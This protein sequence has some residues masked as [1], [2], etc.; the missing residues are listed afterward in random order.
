MIKGDKMKGLGTILNIICIIIG[1]IIGCLFGK[2][3]KPQLQTTLFHVMGISILVIGISGVLEKML[4]IDHNTLTTSGSM[5]III[6]LTSGAIIGE[7]LNIENKIEQL[8]EWLKE[9]SNSASDPVFVS[10]FVNASCTVCIGAM[11]VIGAVED[12]VSGNYMI[13]LS[14]GIVDAVII[15]VMCATSGK[16]CIFSAI[17]VGI[18]QGSVTLVAM[19]LG[20][21]FTPLAIH[22]LAL[23]GSV[24]ISCVGINMIWDIKIRVANLLPSLII[25]MLFA[26]I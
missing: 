5:M 18:F 1:G 10:G 7:A 22:H 16:G 8:G 21:F 25:A 26:L 15:C 14:K 11:A 9:K 6:S 3:I 19:V 17:P 13:L 12:G 24:L 4:V 2:K 23:V 20:P